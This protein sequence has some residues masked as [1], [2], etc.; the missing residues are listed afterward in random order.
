[1]LHIIIFFRFYIFISTVCRCTGRISAAAE[2]FTQALTLDPLL[3]A[4]YEELCILGWFILHPYMKFCGRSTLILIYSLRPWFRGVIAFFTETKEN[5]I[6][7]TSSRKRRKIPSYPMLT[8]TPCMAACKA[9]ALAKTT[10]L[11][12]RLHWLNLEYQHHSRPSICVQG[13]IQYRRPSLDHRC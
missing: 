5:L 6:A 3:W 8:V 11:A 10:T 12:V 13:A 4:A 1:M 2:Q 7:V 9:F